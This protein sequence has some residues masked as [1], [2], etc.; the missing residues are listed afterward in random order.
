VTDLIWK[1]SR[2]AGFSLFA[3]RRL[4]LLRWQKIIPLIV[5]GSVKPLV[6][7]VYPL[8]EASEAPTP[9]D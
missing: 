6:E 3:S 5:N 8:G 9:S 4:P 1:G 7:R 2:M